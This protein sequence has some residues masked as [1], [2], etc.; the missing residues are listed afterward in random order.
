MRRV[1]S[2]RLAMRI[3]ENGGVSDDCKDGV[4]WAENDC[5]EIV[6]DIASMV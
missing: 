6:E 1:I 2:P 5:L 4:A 3:L